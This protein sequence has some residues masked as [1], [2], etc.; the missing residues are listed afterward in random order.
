MRSHEIKQYESVLQTLGETSCPICVLLKNLQSRLLQEGD[1][2]NFLRLCNAHAWAVAAVRQ[3]ETATQIFLSLLDSSS[4]DAKRECSICLP[5]EQ[6]EVLRI[7]ELIAAFDRRSVVH[8]MKTQGVLC[9]PHGL[10]L[11]AE[12]PD[13]IQ[14]LINQVLE[15]RASQL[16]AALA[17]LSAEAARGDA[18][19]CGVFGRVA[20]YLA[21]QRGI[22]L[23]HAGHGDE[24]EVNHQ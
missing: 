22:S 6:E 3:T 13:H 15:R 9:L 4:Y 12:A 11:K 1:A 19:H 5:L 21:G 7:H 8:W 24:Q 18:P 16:R 14:G 23:I 20:E 10:R 17:Q 2:G